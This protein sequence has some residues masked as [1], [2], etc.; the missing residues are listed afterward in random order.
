VIQLA[1]DFIVVIVTAKDRTEAEKISRT[2][3]EMRLIAC[4]NILGGVASCFVWQG[5]IEA[6]DECLILMKTRRSLFN[7]V[8]EQ[9]KAMHSYEVPEVIALPIA[10]GSEEYLAWLASN[11]KP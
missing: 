7:E 9:V 1:E 5:K 10:E 6:A 11:L 8:N 2:L 4:A 3:L